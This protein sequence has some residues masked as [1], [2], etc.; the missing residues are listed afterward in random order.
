MSRAD[1][2]L[3]EMGFDGAPFPVHRPE[4]IA[5]AVRYLVSDLARGV[6]ATAQV[7]DFGDL[8]RSAFP[9]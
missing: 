8:A 1:L 6:N 4:E 2:G 7:V 3:T 5:A 9:A